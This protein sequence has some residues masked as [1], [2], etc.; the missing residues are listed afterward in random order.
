M[1]FKNPLVPI[2]FSEGSRKALELA[3]R[4]TCEKL[5]LLYVHDDQSNTAMFNVVGIEKLLAEVNNRAVAAA[6]ASLE[7]WATETLGDKV[8]YEVRVRVG[9]PPRGILAAIEEGEHDLV[10]MATHGRTGLSRAVTGSVAERV[11]R[12]SPVPVLTT[13]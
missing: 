2:D 12:R 3:A 13:K 7:E 9:W 8:P 4:L 10:V 6:R 11:L 1:L 5:T